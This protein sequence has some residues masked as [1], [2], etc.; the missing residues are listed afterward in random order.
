[1]KPGLY[2]K[3]F[4]AND[5]N[6]FCDVVRKSLSLAPKDDNGENHS[7]NSTLL[8][9]KTIGLH[10]LYRFTMK[11]GRYNKSFRPQLKYRLWRPPESDRSCFQ[12]RFS[13]K[14]KHPFD[15]IIIKDYWVIL[16]LCF[17]VGKA[18]EASCMFACYQ[19]QNWVYFDDSHEI[20]RPSETH[21]TRHQ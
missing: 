19:S 11:P 17:V 6:W 9:S 1:M 16:S 18:A 12:W 13:R 15:S 21:Q 4:P 3:S 10:Y 2:N 7:H 14:P 5:E 8:S 20:N